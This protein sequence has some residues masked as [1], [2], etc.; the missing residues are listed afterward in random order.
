MLVTWPV[1]DKTIPY[2]S[3]IVPLDVRMPLSKTAS[4]I[5]CEFAKTIMVA[6]ATARKRSLDVPQIVQA[7][8]RFHRRTSK[9]KRRL[10][11]PGIQQLPQTGAISIPILFDLPIVIHMDSFQMKLLAGHTNMTKKEALQR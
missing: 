2:L 1:S 10:N 8:C 4:S 9:H 5:L 7:T 11:V 3:I 6:R